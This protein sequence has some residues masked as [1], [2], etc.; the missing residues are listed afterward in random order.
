MRSVSTIEVIN[1]IVFFSKPAVGAR[2]NS[3]YLRVSEHVD[4]A[5]QHITRSIDVNMFKAYW[6]IGKEI[7]E[8]EQYG[9]ARSEYGK[10][11]L[12]GLSTNLIR[13]YKKGFYAFEASKNNWNVR[14]L[15]RQISSFLYDRL[16]KSKNKK[17]TL[18]M[19]LKGQEINTPQDAIKEP[20]VL[21]FMGAPQPH[22]LLR[23][24]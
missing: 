13:K 20:L 22:K 9:E 14:E 19:S 15:R 7:V 17:A 23:S 6:L 8:E 16:S 12:R 18:E 4:S 11:V 3:L 1:R 2:I 5:R 10:A 21:E 24:V